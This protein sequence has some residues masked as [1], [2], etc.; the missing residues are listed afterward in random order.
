MSRA[1]PR[2]TPRQGRSRATVDAVVEATAQVLR[3]H[4]YEA[5]TLRRIAARAGVGVGSIYQYFSSKEGL[6]AAVMA[7][8]LAELAQCV[9]DAVAAT[10]EHDLDAR[11][12]ALVSGV[13]RAHRHD[14]DLHR[15]LAEEVPRVGPFDAQTATLRTIENQVGHVLRSHPDVVRQGPVDVMAAVVVAAVDASIHTV[16]LKRPEL[17]AAVIEDEVTWLVRR[18]LLA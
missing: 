9:A 11:I 18:Y 7:R 17:D 12:R 16:V 10:A 5:A 2:K 6:L 15:V 13:V 1:K 3:S 14:P 8:H 4:G